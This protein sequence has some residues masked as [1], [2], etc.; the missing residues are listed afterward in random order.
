M[1]KIGIAM[2][3]GVG[4]GVTPELMRLL[5]KKSKIVIVANNPHH[6]NINGVTYEPTEDPRTVRI[7]PSLT[8]LG[9]WYN[10]PRPLVDIREEFELIQKKQSKLCRS[11]RDWVVGQFFR[12]YKKVE[13]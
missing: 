5:H 3:M 2:H 9:G 1:K 6:F 12:M 10:R 7:S 4:F 13:V 8:K 11:D